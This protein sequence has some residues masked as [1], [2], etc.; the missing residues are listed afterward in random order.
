MQIRWRGM[1]GRWPGLSC[2][3]EVAEGEIASI[4]R[5]MEQKNIS[6]T[7]FQSIYPV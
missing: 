2:A 5:G 1:L 3:A 7:L 4:F 6:D